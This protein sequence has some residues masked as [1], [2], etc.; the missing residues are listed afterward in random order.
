MHTQSWRIHGP[1]SLQMQNDRAPNQADDEIQMKMLECAGKSYRMTRQRRAVL[2][3][4]RRADSRPDVDWVY[5]EVRKIMPGISLGTV[6]RTLSLL[7]KVGLISEPKSE[8][9]SRY[10]GS[11]K[12]R[13]RVTCIRCGRVAHFVLDFDRDMEAQA[14]SATGF[15]ITGHNL[16]LYGFC[17]DC[18]QKQG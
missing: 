16:E 1:A 5:K 2:D 3:V 12:A 18:A 11:A 7:R 17:P 13:C 15:V 9:S 6:Q 10:D 14:A 4:L 8:V